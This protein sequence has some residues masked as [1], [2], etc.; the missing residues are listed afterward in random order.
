MPRVASHK[1]LK[2]HGTSAE[3]KKIRAGLKLMERY[4]WEE[5]LPDVCVITAL[6]TVSHT[7]GPFVKGKNNCIEINIEPDDLK[8]D[9]ETALSIRHESHHARDIVER[10]LGA[11]D[12]VEDELQVHEETKQDV[13]DAMAKEDRPSHL[14]R[15]D[16]ELEQQESYI[17]HYR[18][19]KR[20]ENQ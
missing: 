6:D 14:G 15:L 18:K 8:D 9:V 5:Y 20:E 7:S 17:E 4:G 3:R 11:V 16:E 2:I 1:R 13:V 12:E 19:Q 10:G